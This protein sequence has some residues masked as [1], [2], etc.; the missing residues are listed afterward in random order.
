VFNF[1]RKKET[2]H[3]LAVKEEVKKMIAYL[4]QELEFLDSKKTM[5][6]VETVEMMV[7]LS[8]VKREKGIKVLETALAKG[9]LYEDLKN[10]YPEYLRQIEDIQGK[11]KLFIA[12]SM[13]FA[14]KVKT[15]LKATTDLPG[16]DTADIK[17]FQKL[18]GL[19]VW[20]L[21]NAYGV[22]TPPLIPYIGVG[23][24]EIEDL[25]CGNDVLVYAPIQKT[26]NTLSFMNYF[27]KDKNNYNTLFN[28]KE[29]VKALALSTKNG[30][31]AAL[32]A[33]L[34]G[35]CTLEKA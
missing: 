28:E 24:Q 1:F 15:G 32:K 9:E 25:R 6:A 7:G 2:A 31:E 18:N 3:A 17:F 16:Y 33:P 20:M 11:K 5:F 10:H 21:N 8:K 22:Y 12:H 14:E 29:T 26:I 23:T 34:R 35:S 30:L 13:E 4:D 19:S 27:I